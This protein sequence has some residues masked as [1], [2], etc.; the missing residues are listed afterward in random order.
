M[1]HV[2]TGMVFSHTAVVQGVKV[3]AVRYRIVERSSAYDA[4]DV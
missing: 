2:V 3:A 4:P 1:G